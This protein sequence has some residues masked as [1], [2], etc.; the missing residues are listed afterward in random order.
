MTTRGRPW[1]RDERLVVLSFYLRTPFSAID[2][3]H[4]EVIAIAMKLGR[5]A[6][7]IAM[8]ALNFASLDPDL[9]ASGRTGLAGGVSRAERELWEEMEQ[10]RDAFAADSQSVAERLGLQAATDLEGFSMPPDVPS[11]QLGTVKLRRLQRFFRQ[12]VLAAYGET[13]AI[14]KLAV[15]D[16]LNT[17]H[18]IPWSESVTRRAD[19]RNGIALNAL[20]D[21][22]FDRGLISF[23][24]QLKVL[25][26][27]RLKRADV[28]EFH[29]LALTEIEGRRAQRPSRFPP[30]PVAL[31][32]HRD[33][34]FM[35]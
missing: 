8:R 32:Y 5:T 21:R 17:S 33:V 16:L 20:Y 19:P 22:A 7:S 1:S 15:P 23:D 35:K 31:E 18:I 13:C 6:S 12:A 14:S 29:R 26:S 3:R 34:V 11:E 2:Q 25:V 28:T 9:R 24:E 10:D 4:P 27:P 30:D